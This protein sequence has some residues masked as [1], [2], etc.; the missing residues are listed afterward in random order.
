MTQPT[1]AAIDLLRKTPDSASQFDEVFG[2][3]A[4]KQYLPASRGVGGTVA[5]VA[6]DIGTG[7]T[8]A[9]KA[10]VRGVEGA[11]NQTSN[12][13]KEAGDFLNE[14]VMDLGQ[15]KFDPSKGVWWEHGTPKDNL[16]QVPQA[17]TPSEPTSTT[18]HLVE[19][20]SQF[21]AGMVGAGKFLKAFG[22]GAAA[23]VSTLGKF[24][25]TTGKAAMADAT[26]FDPH[27]ERL[28]NLIEDHPALKNPVTDF[29]AAKPTDGA[30]EG[31]M[32]NALEGFLSGA[33]LEGLVHGVKAI[34][35]AR[36]GDLHAAADAA[37]AATSA[38]E[39]HT[40]EQDAAAAGTEG[41]APKGA[42]APEAAVA[43]PP[44]AGWRANGTNVEWYDPANPNA[45][46]PAD[47]GAPPAHTE[48]PPMPTEAEAKAAATSTEAA[49]EAGVKPA[50]AAT[51]A[52]GA[53]K[54]DV[55]RVETKPE[56]AFR[57][58]DAEM[59]QYRKNLDARFSVG[60]QDIADTGQHFNF[61]K[62]NTTDDIKA[63]ANSMANVVESH[64]REV[65]GGDEN[66]VRSWEQ[67][68]KNAAAIAE[69]TG[70]DP[71]VMLQRLTDLAGNVKHLDSE[72][73]GY[74]D[75]LVSMSAHSDK[76]AQMLADGTPGTYKSMD[77]VKVAYKHSTQ[78]LANTY[79][80]LK[81]VQ[82]N[83]A[84]ALNAG[85]IPKQVSPEM[86]KALGALNPEDDTML[87]SLAQR[88]AAI[89]RGLDDPG[90]K[91]AAT[92]K[93]LEGSKFDRA[94]S[95]HNEFWFNAVLS[96]VKTHVVNNTVN[97]AKAVFMPG[98]QMV[99]GLLSRNHPQ[100][101]EGAY[102]Y[103]GMTKALKD[104]FA[105]A[106]KAFTV[107][108][109][110]LDY[111]GAYEGVHKQAI[112][113]T[114]FGQE[115]NA[116]I[117]PLINGLGTIVRMPSR[118]LMAEDEFFKQITYRS[119]IY[120]SAMRE[121]VEQGLDPKQTADLVEMR[122]GQA[123]D[124]AGHAN[125]LDG[126]GKPVESRV[127]ALNRSREAT[128]TQPLDYGIGRWIE[129][130]A[131]AHPA[132][133]IIMPFVRVP[134]NI[135]RDVWQH[136]PGLG[137][138]QK[139]LR[140][141][142][143][144]GGERAS[145]AYAKQATGAALWATAA[146]AAFEGKI[147]GYGPIDPQ[148]RKAW[149]MTNQPYSFVST[150][151]ETGKKTFTSFNRADPYGVPFGLAA[152]FAHIAGQLEDMDKDTFATAATLAMVNNLA[153]KTYLQGLIQAVG[154][155]SDDRGTKLQAYAEQRAASYIPNILG[156]AN[157]DPYMREVRDV[158][159]AMQNKIP[160]FSQNLPARRDVL[161][162]PMTVPMGYPWSAINPFVVK[163][164]DTDTVR[165]EM[166]RLASGPS[167]IRFPMPA[168]SVNGLDLTTVKGEDGVSVY[169]KWQQNIGELTIGGRTL[170]DKLTDTINS[171]AYQN[172]ADGDAVFK[173]SRKV[174][175]IQ[176]DLER[177]RT[178]AL[179]DTMKDFPEL[180]QALHEYKSGSK[181]VRAGQE[182]GS[183]P[184]SVFT[185]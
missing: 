18:G 37:D 103:V 182:P 10:I 65:V 176:H 115:G 57:L 170:H 41:T 46:A 155:L 75:M 165:D 169:D 180:K 108:D 168:K 1:Q 121:G 81:G 84:R 30:A 14:H 140:E 17:I 4:S 102:Q 80:L 33:A 20:V 181:R 157:P 32:K 42:T 107:Q 61:S 48:V 31:R 133:R 40:A 149:L 164:V 112:T 148:Q 11:V 67:V 153:S 178:H 77:E 177:Y 110:V 92:R 161:G 174:D 34:K 172:A 158:F 74:G 171:N 101:L 71:R 119:R 22:V 154:L 78:L 44:H 99:A 68:K 52:T 96:G 135:I 117:A 120:A 29:L 167:G 58:D 185:Q 173:K 55:L 6:S 45:K 39:A 2:E 50:D 160:G 109:N 26:V 184:F 141:D 63:A 162:D 89:A 130:G 25:L 56:P 12:A 146:G 106:Q 53:P 21:T 35:L 183:D 59:E 98:E 150:D 62:W 151:P 91:A 60:G 69:I 97:L 122:M 94:L 76:L 129:S 95:V 24:A 88:Q 111:R 85:K 82:T 79:G 90:A 163:S 87:M 93:L 128:F 123:F 49:P 137:L 145:M 175:M 104:S 83:T 131:Q 8:E 124:P 116:S 3:G 36:N 127:A 156:A 132:I 113:A 13:A 86:M 139:Q 66:G 38:H 159:S 28:S 105:M 138:V 23:P 100:Y 16:V 143:Q 147:T 51:D 142:I 134:T 5:A 152:D 7:I 54:R 179:R 166:A 19:G 47:A 118:L 64:L 114:M 70:S 9:P 125:L 73:I 144:A 126:A 72:T 15:I 136:T 43:A 27:A